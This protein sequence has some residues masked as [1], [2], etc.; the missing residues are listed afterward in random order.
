MGFDP[1]KIAVDYYFGNFQYW[2]LPKLAADAL[3]E[4]YDGAA[5]RHIAGLSNPVAG[6]IRTEEIDSAFREMGVEA[7]ISKDEAR[8]SLAAECARAAL[9]GRSNVSDGATHIRIRL[10]E[11][12]DPPEPLKRIVTL[13]REA[14]TASRFNWS[15]LESS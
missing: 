7:P 5:L 11:I 14:E 8:M 9:S 15:R 13:S 2:K 4:G 6:D 1:K 12:S 10:C 3:S